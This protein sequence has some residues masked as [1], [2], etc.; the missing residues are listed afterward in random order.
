MPITLEQLNTAAPA[1]FMRLLDGTYEHSSWIAERAVAKRPAGGFASLAALKLA[2]VDV[3]REAG[4]DAQI[5]LIRAHP[6]LAGKAMVAK[7]LT[8]ESTNE[9]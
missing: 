9:Q 8:A 1:E 6:E 7:T 5:A 2:L 4:R 3:V